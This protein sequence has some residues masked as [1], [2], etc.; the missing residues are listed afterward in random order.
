M[1]L[2]FVTDLSLYGWFFFF[3]AED[4]IRDGTVTGVQTCALPICRGGHVVDAVTLR[5]GRPRAAD[6]S[7]LRH[8]PGR[9]VDGRARRHDQG[10]RPNRSD[11]QRVHILALRPMAVLCGGRARSRD[12]PASLAVDVAH[13][14][15]HDGGRLV[16]AVG[17]ALR[18]ALPHRDRGE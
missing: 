10:L 3:Q 16:V 4:G 6:R 9:A 11:W 8:Y 1:R 2:C 14:P 17:A 5:A 13:P 7:A 18:A 12:V 15:G